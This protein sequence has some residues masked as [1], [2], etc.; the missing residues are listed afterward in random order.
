MLNRIKTIKY[1]TYLNYCIM[2]KIRIE[3]AMDED[4]LEE[5]INR[6]NLYYFEEFCGSCDYFDNPQS[7]PFYGKVFRATKWKEIQ[8]QNFWD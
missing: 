6:Q 2:P 3:D 5:Y 7:C 1:T 8:C 4:S